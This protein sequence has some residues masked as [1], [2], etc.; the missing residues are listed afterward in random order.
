[1]LV[2][3]PAGV[4]VQNHIDQTLIASVVS[5]VFPL[6]RRRTPLFTCDLLYKRVSDRL[7]QPEPQ[8][9]SSGGVFVVMDTG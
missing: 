9:T 2:E 1:M 3:G 8:E 6:S 4:Q 7:I 5:S